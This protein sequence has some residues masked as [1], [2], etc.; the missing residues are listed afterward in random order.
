MDYFGLPQQTLSIIIPL[1]A[2]TIGLLL[3][4]FVITFK[5]IFH[6]EYNKIHL[7]AYYVCGITIAIGTYLS[8]PND[9]SYNLYFAA[10]IVLFMTCFSWSY[11]PIKHSVF[12]SVVFIS[13]YACI[14][15]FVHKFTQGTEFL[16]FLSHLFYLISV[17]VIAAIGQGIRDSLIFR[18]L[19]LQ[20]DLKL[21][22]DK[23]TEEAKKHKK[24]ANIDELTG[25][26][27][28][29]AICN[30]IEKII[31]EG[32]QK[33]TK[34]IL[35]FIDLNGFKSINDHYGHDSGDTVLQT[36][37]Y[38]L[39]QI[40]REN[41]HVARLGGDEFL[42]VCNSP[43]DSKTFIEDLDDNI[44][45]MVAAPNAYH[46]KILRVGVS[47]GYSSYPDDGETIEALINAA[48]ADMYIDK[49]KSKSKTKLV[50]V[51]NPI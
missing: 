25:I 33:D 35:V 32:E 20:E 47:V 6:K 27:N 37:A 4:L 23:K 48:D 8:Q 15:F 46:G 9:Y 5:S 29:R 21:V 10:Y 41:D 13:V 38:R 36:T 16:T 51:I 17:V 44:K 34:L 11:L 45:T 19:A 1:R 7:F 14:K 49:Q 31:A 30:K 26:P 28:R 42:L 18:N 2:V 22:V 43:I 24:L 12:M 40:I 39:Q 50:S 3:A